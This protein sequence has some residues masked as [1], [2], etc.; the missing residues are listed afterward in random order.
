MPAIRRS[1]SRLASKDAAINVAD[2]L[3]ASELKAKTPRKR[4]AKSTDA[5]QKSELPIESESNGLPVVDTQVLPVLPVVPGP[6]IQPEESFVPAVLSFDFEEAKR[7]LIQVD[8]RFEELFVK[9]QCKP[10]EHL[11][12]DSNAWPRVT[13]KTVLTHKFKIVRLPFQSCEDNR[14]FTL[15]PFHHIIR[16]GQ[17]ISWLAARSITHKF[18]RLYDPSLPEKPSDEER[19][20]ITS[21]PT[22]HQVANTDIAVLRTAGLSARK[23]EYIRDLAARFADDRLSTR[24]LLEANDEELA[25]ML[26]EVRGIGRVSQIFLASY[27]RIL[28][29]SITNGSGRVVLPS[30]FNGLVLMFIAVDMFAIFSLR[31]PDILPVGK[32]A[33]FVT[34]EFLIEFD[35]PGDLG[36]QRGMVRWFLSLHSPVHSYSLSPEKVGNAVTP[37][38]KSK[39]KDG[40]GLSKEKQGE[41]ASSVLPGMSYKAEDLP[42]IPPAFTPSIKKALNKIGG[43]VVPL[44]TGI[45]VGVL[46]GRLD[47]KK[48]IKG[49]FL[50]P[51][52]MTELTECWKP[53]RS[54][55]G[56]LYHTHGLTSH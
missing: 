11:E 15:E 12:Q 29:A 25:Q 42:S 6:G 35:F 26:I 41:G 30:L 7:H 24:K 21:F 39:E 22:P 14:H 38:K 44:P 23:A 50:T 53:Y 3:P 32:A 2:Q 9:M 55:G 48:K 56:M 18:I 34:S 4:K 5:T 10:F 19:R 8:Q 20:N 40:D 47:G 49:A 36:V 37:K 1:S 27:T 43:T 16:R 28:I 17:Q 51:Q 45:D 33:V 13:V 54:L 46:K 52:E 31:R